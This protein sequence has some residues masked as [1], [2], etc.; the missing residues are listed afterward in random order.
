MYEVKWLRTA[1]DDLDRIAEFIVQD[2]PE[3]ARSFTFEI[4][5]RVEMLGRFPFMGPSSEDIDARELV[6]HRIIWSCTVWSERQS[7]F[8]KSGTL[9]RIAGRANDVR[10]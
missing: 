1:L 2:N 4:F 8:F 9:R 10:E 6:V 5:N 7:K 3:R